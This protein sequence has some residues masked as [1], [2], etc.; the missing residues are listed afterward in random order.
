[1]T[2]F[3]SYNPSCSQ[4]DQSKH[5]PFLLMPSFQCN[6]NC[7]KRVPSHRKT[8]VGCWPLLL[9]KGEYTEADANSNKSSP[10]GG[11]ERHAEKSLIDCFL[12]PDADMLL[13]TSEKSSW[14][15][16]RFWLGEKR[17]VFLII[18]SSEI[19]LQ[20]LVNISPCSINFNSWWVVFDGCH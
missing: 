6:P 9:S 2:E 4:S 5:L 14:S 19:W 11:E 12:E 7:S 3:S 16:S 20:P 18:L 10:S 15:G 17:R 8:H 13:C 1:M